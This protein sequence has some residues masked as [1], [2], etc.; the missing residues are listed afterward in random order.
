MELQTSFSRS[1]LTVDKGKETECIAAT[2]YVAPLS[3]YLEW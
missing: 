1:T 3:V 2:G